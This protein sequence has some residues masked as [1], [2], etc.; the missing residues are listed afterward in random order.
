MLSVTLFLVTLMNFAESIEDCSNQ[1]LA[2]HYWSKEDQACVPCT[3]C[4]DQ[5]LITLLGCGPERDTQ[6]GTIEDFRYDTF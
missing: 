5:R 1:G 6:C 4:H 3:N 2:G